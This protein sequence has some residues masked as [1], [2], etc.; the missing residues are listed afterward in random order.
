MSVQVCLST[1]C[2]TAFIRLSM[3]L[4]RTWNFAVSYKITQVHSYRAAIANHRRLC[5][6]NAMLSD[7]I[8]KFNASTEWYRPS[9]SQATQ[10]RLE[11]INHKRWFMMSCFSQVSIV[12]NLWQV[13][14]C[15][16]INGPLECSG[17]P[18]DKAKQRCTYYVSPLD[19]ACYFSNSSSLHVD[20]LQAPSLLLPILKSWSV[21]SIVF[22][23]WRRW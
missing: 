10:T 8:S 15:R 2:S 21:I 14:S 5:N 23:Q 13:C 3:Q 12:A 19:K 22:F 6:S 4:P 9:C 17:G 20:R 1:L 18:N 7:Q 11:R 16:V